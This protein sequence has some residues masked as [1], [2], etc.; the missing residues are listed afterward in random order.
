MILIKDGRVIDP[1][2]RLDDNLD[3]VIQDNKIV[4]IGKYQRSDEYEDI[5]EAKGLIVAPGL[6]DVHVHFRDP[7]F[8][9]KENISSGA[10]AAAKGGVTT[11]VCMANTNPVVDSTEILKYVLEQGKKTEINVLSVAAVTKGMSGKE[12][13]DMDELK[14]AGAVGFSDDGKPILDEPVIIQAMM[15]AKRLNVPLSLHEEHP[16]LVFNAGINQGAVAEKMG[17]NGAAAAAEDVLVARDCMLA[18]HT[19]ACVHIQHISSGN[20]VRM[21]RLAKEMGA[22]VYAEATPHHF[23]LTEDSVLLKGSCA[24]VNPPVRTRKDRYEII[25]GLKDGTIDI[26]ATD[27]APHSTQ[28]KEKALTEAPSGMIGLETMLALGVTELVRKGHLSML[29]L[30]E[31]MT[32]NP[33]GLYRMSVG[34]I[35][36]GAAADLVIFDENEKWKVD[37]FVSKSCNSPFIGQELYGRVKYTICNGRIAYKDN[38]QKKY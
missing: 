22:R 26:I 20:S 8:T 1:K 28:E 7:G 31:K 2:S 27:H 14:K 24:K 34:S 12:L 21:V 19:G 13:T 33:A 10:K 6:I 15:E 3:V 5:I 36:E 18:I 32:L 23:S 25:E 16:S 29:Q 9:Y 30:I 37:K 35:E 11:V 4:K 17:I 38:L